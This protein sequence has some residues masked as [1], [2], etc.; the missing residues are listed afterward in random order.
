MC[1]YAMWEA[2]N[3]KVQSV[4]SNHLRRAKRRAFQPNA[5][6]REHIWLLTEKNNAEGKD[7]KR[8]EKDK[9]R[10]TM[11]GRDRQTENRKGR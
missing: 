6:I 5:V 3:V 7:S 4:I 9:E 1:R 2:S 11:R 10:E 8:T